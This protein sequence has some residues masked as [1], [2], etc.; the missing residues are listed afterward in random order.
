MF[1]N[2]FSVCC[3][4]PTRPASRVDLPLS[5]LFDSHVSKM[6]LKSTTWRNS[7]VS[8]SWEQIAEYKLL[9]RL[10]FFGL[11]FD[12][13][14]R[15]VCTCVNSTALKGGEP[16]LGLRPEGRPQSGSGGVTPQTPNLREGGTPTR[17]RSLSSGRPRAGPVGRHPPPFKGREETGLVEPVTPP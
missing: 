14:E 4:T 3:V 15:D 1:T 8:S 17:R 10:E 12:R 11:A 2:K 9:E 13:H 5:G 16:A 7:P 6:S